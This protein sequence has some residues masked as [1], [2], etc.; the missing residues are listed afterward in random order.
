MEILDMN[1]DLPLQV[2]FM[3]VPVGTPDNVVCTIENPGLFCFLNASV[4]VFQYPVADKYMLLYLVAFY[5]YM[6]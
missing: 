1:L 2:L 4:C 5:I 3:N 6:S